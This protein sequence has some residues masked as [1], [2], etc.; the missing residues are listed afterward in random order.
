MKVESAIA[1]V[2]AIIS[3]GAVVVAIVAI[4]MQNRQFKKQREPIIAP[5]T[6]NFNVKLP[7][8]HLDWTN[9][10]ELDKKL[11]NLYWTGGKD[12]DGNFSK[13]TIPI[14]NYG[15]TTVFNIRYNYKFINVKEVKQSLEHILD[16]TNYAIKIDSIKDDLSFF[17]LTFKNSSKGEISKNIGRERKR[18]DLIQPGE[19]VEISLPGYFLIITNYAFILSALDD[20]KLPILEL[21]ILYTDINYVEWEVKHKVR[22]DNSRSYRGKEDTLETAFISEFVSRKKIKETF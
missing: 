14:Y 4:I 11:S 5:A 13:T 21:T 2:S 6:R 12:L 1:L 3:L 22:I 17:T 7:E 20:I 8:T 10:E 16:Y 9:G 19:K 15:G 18:E